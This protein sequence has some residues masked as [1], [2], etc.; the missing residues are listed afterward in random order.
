[1]LL[2][3]TFRGKARK[4]VVMANRNAFYYILDRES[5][6]FLQGTF[7]STQTWA[8]GLDDSGRPIR[9]PNTFPSEEGTLVYPS[10]QGATN[11]FSPSYSPVTKTLYVAVREMGSIF[12]KSEVEYKPGAMFTGGG[13]R[14]LDGDKAYG[15]I[16]ALDSLTGKKKWEFKLQSPPWAGVLATAG[17]L[18]F[19]GSNEGNFY[20]LDAVNGRALWQ[21]QTGGGIVANPVS[22]GIDGKQH[23]AIAAGQ[24]ILVFGL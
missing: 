12:Y 24:A 6:Q 21:F 3:A 9:L 8:K 17:G 7:Y 15:A 14:A 18:V 2:E 22:F 11:W 23:V 1:M 20:A 4:L 10:L 13:E 5:G 19:G 16:R